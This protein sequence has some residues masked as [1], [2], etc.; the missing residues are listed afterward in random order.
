MFV[1]IN[2]TKHPQW[3]PLG[4]LSGVRQ[5][6]DRIKTIF[7]LAN[8]ARFDWE[9]QNTHRWRHLSLS[10]PR[11]GRDFVSNFWSPQLLTAIVSDPLTGNLCT[12]EWHSLSRL[13]NMARSRDHSQSESKESKKRK[14]FLRTR[15]VLVTSIV[16][17]RKRILNLVIPGSGCS[18]TRKMVADSGNN[19]HAKLWHCGFE[20]GVVKADNNQAKSRLCFQFPNP[21]WQS[22]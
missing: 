16:R 5:I 18:C 12:C 2:T 6:N 19:E 11:L 17:L 7:S 4:V 21:Q 1:S 20:N 9:I 13:K 14:N 22:Y 8:I 15:P 10:N 3:R